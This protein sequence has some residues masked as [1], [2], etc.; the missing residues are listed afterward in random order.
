MFLILLYIDILHYPA[1]K[2]SVLG[3]EPTILTSSDSKGPYRRNKWNKLIGTLP[4]KV[5]T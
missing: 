4:S 2:D 1:E 5:K 3:R